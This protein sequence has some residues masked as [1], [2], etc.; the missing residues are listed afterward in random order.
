MT[1]YIFLIVL[2]AFAVNT[3]SQEK[4]HSQWHPRDFTQHGLKK[5]SPTEHADVFAT[6]RHS[7]NAVGEKEILVKVETSPSCGH[8]SRN[9]YNC[10]VKD[11]HPKRHAHH[12][13]IRKIHEPFCSD[14]GVYIPKPSYGIY[15]QSRRC[16]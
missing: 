14:C 11:A 16:R 4:H 3:R 8:H 12:K 5:T 7:R 6:A 2:F 15:W 13:H 9:A 1:K 10:N